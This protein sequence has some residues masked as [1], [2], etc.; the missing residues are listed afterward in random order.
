M[1]RDRVTAGGPA[2][3]PSD[4]SLL[5][6]VDRRELAA[7]F[8]G[9]F[10][11]AIARATLVQSL[12]ARPDGW[13]WA[14]FI[15]NVLGA[16]MLGYFATRLNERLPLSPYRRAFLGTGLCGALTTFS[17]MMVELLKMIEGS[18]WALTAGYASAS[19]GAGL[20]AV[21]VSSKIVRRASLGL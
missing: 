5:P 21:F 10:V 14:T 15:V 19:I 8:A 17:T 11:G 1:E 7:I 3:A 13:P 9:G 6:R 4:A 12:L 2:G 16:F 18:H 20:A